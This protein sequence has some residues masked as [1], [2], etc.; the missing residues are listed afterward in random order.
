MLIAETHNQAPV[1]GRSGIYVRQQMGYRPFIP[2]ALPPVPPLRI[3]SGL[4]QDDTG[5]F[6]ICSSRRAGRVAR[7][8][9]NGIPRNYPLMSLGP[10][11]H[12]DR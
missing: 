7:V 9:C 8:V 5:A 4:Q 10:A 2:T 1:A 6:S 11:E 3:G 12:A